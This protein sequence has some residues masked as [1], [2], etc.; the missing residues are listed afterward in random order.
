MEEEQFQSLLNLFPVVRSRDYCVDSEASNQTSV[1]SE[2]DKQIMEW[3]NAW[4]EVDAEENRTERSEKEDPFW[5]HL[6]SSAEQT[7]GA[8]KAKQFCKAF[9]KVHEQLVYKA[10]PLEAVRRITAHLDPN[11]N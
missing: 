4:E 11:P 7:M 3:D 9:R 6:R 2:K 8:E 1:P 10:L 5:V